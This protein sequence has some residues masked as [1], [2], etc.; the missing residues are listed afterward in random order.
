MNSDVTDLL[1]ACS[2]RLRLARGLEAAACAATVAAL[3]SAAV[4]LAAG[5]AAWLGHPLGGPALAVPAGIVPLAALGGAV[6]ALRRLRGGPAAVALEM[7]LRFALRE[8]H[9][10]AVELLAAGET[11]SP[12]AELVCRQALAAA[13][14]AGLPGRPMWRR[15]RRLPAAMGLSLLMCLATLALACGLD[16]ARPEQPPQSGAMPATTPGPRRLSAEQERQLM[17]ALRQVA[18]QA[19]EP[20]VAA[21]AV[22]AEQAA[23]TGEILDLSQALALLAEHGL[24]LRPL[25]R[26]PGMDRTARNS[27]LPAVTPAPAG[28]RPGGGSPLMAATA[29]LEQPYVRVLNP[30]Y[31]ATSPTTG[32]GESA[33]SSG[34]APWAEA[35][36]R[37]RSAAAEAI[38]SGQVPAKHRSLVR[39]FFAE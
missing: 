30:D 37:A 33:A 12:R 34:A 6:M 10:T 36:A 15:T 20:A 13:A 35:W 25:A 17:A 32:P 9:S 39:E 8:R 21:A 27:T 16:R 4:G 31:R 11:G 26:M 38:A 23:K 5:T 14:E 28:H 2:R 29:P 24:E 19:R 7:D 18:Q 1:K 3:A 22:R